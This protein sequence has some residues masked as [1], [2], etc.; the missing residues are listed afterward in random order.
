MPGNLYIGT[1][2][3]SYPHWTGL[4]YPDGLKQSHWL[5]YYSNWFNTVEINHTFYNSPTR[6]TFEQWASQTPPGFLFTLKAPR[7][8]SHLRRLQDA[9][10]ILGPFLENAAALG[11][12][13]GMLLLQIPPNFGFQ[14]ERLDS[15]LNYLSAQSIAP[16]LRIALEIRDA[17]WYNRECVSLLKQYQAALVLADYPGFTNEGPLT[18]RHV[19]IRKHGPGTLY[20]SDYSTLMLHIEEERIVN[21]LKKN[22]DVSIYF[23]ND[24]AGFA[25]K[26]AGYLQAAIHNQPARNPIQQRMI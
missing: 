19:Y 26:D 8:F 1:C 14:P 16:R 18:S 25:V 15:A 4:F 23:N 3:W 22:R 11:P 13:F 21:L 9:P 6:E 7:R 17:S 5:A 12:K 24:A 20:A 10:G 2:G